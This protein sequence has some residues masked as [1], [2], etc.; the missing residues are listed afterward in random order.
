MSNNVRQADLGDAGVLADIH[1]ACFEKEWSITEIEDLLRGD[2]NTGWVIEHGNDI[3]AFA[4]LMHAGDDVEILTI[5]TSPE[6]KRAGYAK[7]L[8]CACDLALGMDRDVREAVDKRWLLEVAIDNVAAIGLYESL[9]F[10][11]IGQRKNYYAKSNG[12][13][14]DA[15]VYSA[16]LSKLDH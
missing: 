11:R 6:Y 10:E 13:F 2:S 3:C 14:V 8:L 4:I 12:V 7:R 5:A 15:L 16:K 1:A 9:G